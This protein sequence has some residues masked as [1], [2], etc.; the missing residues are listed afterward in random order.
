MWNQHWTKARFDPSRRSSIGTAAALAGTSWGVFAQPAVRKVRLAILGGI[1]PEA[2]RM[3]GGEPS[4]H[5]AHEIGFGADV[6]VDKLVL[7]ASRAHAALMRGDL[8]TYRGLITVADDCTLMAPFGGK[9]TRA[10][11][12][13]SER[14]VSIGRFFRHGRDSSL[15]VVQGVSLEQAAALAR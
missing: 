6:D 12:L 13:S 4:R 9:P 5:G 3:R 2:G 8:D 14:W 10:G 11:D 15:A 7:R 1:R